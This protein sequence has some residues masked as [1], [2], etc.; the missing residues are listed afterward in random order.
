MSGDLRKRFG[1]LLAAHRKNRGF[2]QAHLAEVSD[3][4]VDMIS[5][6]ES[7]SSGARFQTIEK[8]ATALSIDPA[9]LFTGDLPKS[10]LSNPAMSAM[11]VQLSKM[12]EADLDWL[13]SI[14][15]GLMSR[16]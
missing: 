16:R 6:L 15:P 4:S 13:K 3:L 9:E 1:S 2:T 10:A 11:V 12:S 14:L 5:R 8:L 7:G